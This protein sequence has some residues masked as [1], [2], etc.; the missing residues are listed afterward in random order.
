MQSILEV[1]KKSA[2]SYEGN[3]INHE[4]QPFRGKLTLRPILNGRGLSLQFS[5]SGMDGTLYH[6]EESTI[7]P[8][9][10]DKLTLWN[11][12]TNTPGLL[13]HPLKRT[14]PRPGAR[15]SFVFGFNAPEKKQS[16]REEIALELWE[17]GDLSYTYSWGMPGGEFKERSGVRMSSSPAK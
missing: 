12:N 5:A 9:L 11:F 17:N 3:G 14:Q 7:A 13:P 8:S 6:Q 1:L 10:D 2:G 16:F 4:G 15:Q